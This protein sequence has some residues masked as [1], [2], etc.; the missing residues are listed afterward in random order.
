MVSKEEYIKEVENII[1]NELGNNFIT[2]IDDNLNDDWE[3]YEDYAK[4]RS[5]GNIIRVDHVFVV[6]LNGICFAWNYI[7]ENND[8]VEGI[9]K[10]DIIP[11]FEKVC[12]DSRRIGC[13]GNIVFYGE[14][15]RL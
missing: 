1:F 3:D 15:C 2:D 5:E 10:N 6:W 7:H 8:E 4:Q 12:D 11:N 13:K 9:C 14:Y